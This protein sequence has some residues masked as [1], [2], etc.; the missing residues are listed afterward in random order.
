MVWVVWVFGV[1][2]RGVD[3]SSADPHPDTPEPHPKSN[4][5][6]QCMECILIN[7]TLTLSPSPPTSTYPHTQDG[8]LWATVSEQ[9]RVTPGEIRDYFDVF[10]KL[11]NLKV[12]DYK[13]YIRLYGDIA[14]NDGYY[15]V[16]FG[17][18]ADAKV[19]K[20][21][22][23]FVYKRAANGKW[24]IIDH[25]SSAMPTAPAGLKPA[26]TVAPPK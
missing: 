23:V 11:P 2:A 20:A 24:E 6:C 9:L 19:T 26:L 8:V 21:R 4:D 10:A 15:T 25:H 17:S 1:G 7:P 12:T 22:Y 5:A 18:G 14:I 3:R 16:H 13:P